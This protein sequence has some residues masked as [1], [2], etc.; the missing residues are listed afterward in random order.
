M[1]NSFRLVSQQNP[2]KLSLGHDVGTIMDD[3]LETV[4]FWMAVIWGPGLLLGALLLIP[5]RKS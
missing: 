2:V 1:H 5:G 4:I 3:I